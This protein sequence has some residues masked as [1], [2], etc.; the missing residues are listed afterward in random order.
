MSTKEKLVNYINGIDDETILSELLEFIEIESSIKNLH[1]VRPEEREAIE[2]GL[3]DLDSGKFYTQEESDELT[4]KW[5][6]GK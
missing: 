6:K 2:E 4:K 1:S 3:R 5:F